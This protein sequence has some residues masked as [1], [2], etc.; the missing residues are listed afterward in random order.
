MHFTEYYVGPFKLESDV[1]QETAVAHVTHNFLHSLSLTSFRVYSASGQFLWLWFDPLEIL[2][3]PR[4]E[5][6][7]LNVFQYFLVPFSIPCLSLQLSL[8]YCF[9]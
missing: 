4:V 6:H 5:K 8:K 9:F 2:L 1:L 7:Y 3:T